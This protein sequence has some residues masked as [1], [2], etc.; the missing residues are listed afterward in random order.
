MEGG[1][2]ALFLCP[3]ATTSELQKQP[4]C[5]TPLSLSFLVVKTEI[6]SFASQGR[7]EDSMREVKHLG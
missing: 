6:M 7:W 1:G 4:N 5:F 3:D 2:I